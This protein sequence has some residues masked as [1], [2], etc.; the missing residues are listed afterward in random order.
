MGNN[1]EKRNT[2]NLDPDKAKKISESFNNR[3][4]VFGNKVEEFLEWVK[5]LL[6]S[7]ETPDAGKK[8]QV[9]E[10]LKDL[11]TPKQQEDFRRM[12]EEKQM[13]MMETI[14]SKVEAYPPAKNEILNATHSQLAALQEGVSN[15]VGGLVVPNFPEK[16]A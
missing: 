11:Q 3:N 1:I 2:L 16:Q 15:G 13:A 9:A 8:K 4:E 6:S 5:Q 12:P 7:G 10:V 14:T